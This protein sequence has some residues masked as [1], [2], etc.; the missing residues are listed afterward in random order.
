MLAHSP[1]LPLIIDYDDED[2]DVTVEDKKDI[3][4][5]LEQRDRVRRIRLWMPSLR[6]QKLQ[7][8]MRNTQSWNT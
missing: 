7:L 2:W 6:L 4:L 8:L 3:V 5:A 1:P